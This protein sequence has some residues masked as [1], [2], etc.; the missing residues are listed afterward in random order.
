VLR[1]RL[2]LGALIIA[3][4]ASL[5]WADTHVGRPGIFLL[6]LAIVL[7][8]LATRE[9]LDIFRAGGRSPVAWATYLGTLLPVLAAGAPIAWAV[10]P[11]NCP[12]GRVGWLAFGLAAG[13]MVALIGEMLRYR[14][15]G[16]T[17]TNLAASSLSI[18]YL[19]GLLGFLIQLRLLPDGGWPT[20][21]RGMIALLSLVV[22]VKLSDT[23]QFT[24]GKLFG[25][26]KLAPAISPG[27]TWE[28]ALGGVA[29]SVVISSMLLAAVFEKFGSEVDYVS[30]LAYCLLV[31]IA[32]IVGD[33]AESMLKRDAGV[34][35]SSQWLPGLGGIL[36]LLDSLLIAAPVAYFC[37]VGGLMGL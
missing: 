1:W 28:G 8:L 26:H 33:L 2:I 30:I 9:L 22:V 14:Q 27:K 21:D 35:D 17:I 18:L 32:G 7:C 5:C 15:P 25:R 19:G 34:K 10:Y 16:S 3:I 6:P 31:C 12:V 13:L 24:F 36:D 11:Q 29:A 20:G 4:L 37:W 23:C